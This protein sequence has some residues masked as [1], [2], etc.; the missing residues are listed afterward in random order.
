MAKFTLDQKITVVNGYL[1]GNGSLRSIGKKHGIY[2]MHSLNW[3][4]L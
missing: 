2:H 1:E 3:I 4:A